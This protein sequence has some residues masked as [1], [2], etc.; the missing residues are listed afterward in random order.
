V[1]LAVL[2]NLA[3]IL[4]SDTKVNHKIPPLGLSDSA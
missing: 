2:R 4:K 1:A 3:C